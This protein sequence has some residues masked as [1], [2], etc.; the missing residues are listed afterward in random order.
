MYR[1]LDPEKVV[2]TI[3]ALRRR[4]SERFPGA[5]LADVCAELNAIAR[6]NSKR[7][8]AIGMQAQYGETINEKPGH[9]KAESIGHRNARPVTV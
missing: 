8:L 2:D 5:G 3:S 1:A 9:A 6:E 7:A 4:I